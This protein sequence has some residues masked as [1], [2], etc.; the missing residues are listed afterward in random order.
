MRT[1]I[2]VLLK[3]YQQ[4]H[5]T[6]LCIYFLDTAQDKVIKFY[7]WFHVLEQVAFKQTHIVKV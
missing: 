1:R 2:T 4:T 3:N 7:I 6:Y 5:C